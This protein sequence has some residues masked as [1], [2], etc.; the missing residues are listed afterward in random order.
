MAEIFQILISS[1]LLFGSV[2]RGFPGRPILVSKR[3]HMRN[4]GLFTIPP[5]TTMI[6]PESNTTT[7]FLT[8]S[9][10]MIVEMNATTEFDDS[11]EADTI[12]KCDEADRTGDIPDCT[13]VRKIKTFGS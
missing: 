5:L 2:A 12:R 9:A 13:W 1:F 11:E 3:H 8:T 7:Y 4:S 6:I 10:T